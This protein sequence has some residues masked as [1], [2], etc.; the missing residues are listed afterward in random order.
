[1][2]EYQ[3]LGA[4]VVVFGKDGTILMGKRKNSY[5]SGYY[6]VPGGRLEQGEPLLICATRELTEET[7]L[8]GHDIQYVG[9]VRDDEKEYDFIHFVYVCHAYDGEPQLMEPDKCEGWEW[10]SPQELPEKILRGH[11]AAIELALSP[12]Q[13]I[14]DLAS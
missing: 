10:I 8:I 2:S 1:M 9:T 11:R 6:G 3:H 5:K 12:D 7:G 13:H 14:L 4:C